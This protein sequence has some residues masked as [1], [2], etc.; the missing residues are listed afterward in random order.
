MGGATRG[1]AGTALACALAAALA[2]VV[3][4]AEPRDTGDTFVALAAGRD[5]VA[6]RLGRPDDWSFVTRGRVWIDQNWGSGVLFYAAHAA[7]GEVGLLVLKAALLA[8]ALAAIGI[9]CTAAGAPRPLAL[10]VAG[11]AVLAAR[12]YVDLRPA[13][14]TF[15]LSAGTLAALEVSWRRARAVWGAVALV[16]LWS[17]MHGGFVFGLGMLALFG[18][19]AGAESLTRPGRRSALRP[20]AEPWLGLLVATVA[21]AAASPFGIA[22]L[23]HPLV[24]ATDPLWREI[25]EWQPLIGARA[26]TFGTAWEFLLGLA[27]LAAGLARAARL[28]RLLDVAGPRPGVAGFRLALAS[29]AV[30]MAFAAR[31]MIPLALVAMSPVVARAWAEPA[32]RPGRVRALAA[33]LALAAAASGPRLRAHYWPADPDLAAQSTFGRM[34]RAQHFPVGLCEH[35]RR[36]AIAGPT[37]NEWR[38]E[39]YLR[40]RCPGLHVFIGGRAQQIYRPEEM[41]E[42]RHILESGDGGALRAVGATFAALPVSRE[43]TR[44]LDALLGDPASPWAVVYFDGEHLLLGD[45]RSPGGAAAV[46]RLLAGRDRFADPA[47]ASLSRAAALASPALRTP[48]QVALEALLEGAAKRPAAFLY[49]MAA[50]VYRRGGLPLEHL[51][52]AFQSELVRLVRLGRTPSRRLLRARVDLADALA[53]VLRRE[54]RAEGADRAA[55]VARD[56]RRRLAALPPG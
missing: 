26:A 22:N 14:L 37:F 15:L 5:V 21:A 42:W 19:C 55:R 13:L 20:S 23:T 3:V 56:A 53:A 35:V 52:T 45:R 1:R 29:V 10:V 48:P 25:L 8:G 17:Q 7:A 11:A 6:G 32:L 27:L 2:V 16:A 47:A 49:R 51:T 44:L 4:W 31:R 38:W 39:G 54:G 9:A 33:V 50:Y 34:I 41:R 43:T 36:N 46:D 18:L 30:A 28:G 40:W 12:S 24:V